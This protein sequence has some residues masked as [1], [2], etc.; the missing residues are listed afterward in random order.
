MMVV[1]FRAIVICS[2][3]LMLGILPARAQ[4]TAP[5]RVNRVLMDRYGKSGYRFFVEG[6]Y[7]AVQLKQKLFGAALPEMGIGELRWGFGTVEP[8]K[9]DF[10]H[11]DER[12][13]FG[14]YMR[15]DW[16]P[17]GT[18]G[19]AVQG[20]LW[21]VG[22]GARDGYGYWP[23]RLLITPTFLWGLEWSRW[24]EEPSQTLSAADSS[25]A[26]RYD[27]RICFGVTAEAGLKLQVGWNVS[28]VGGYEFGVVYPRV[29]FP[30]WV[31]GFGLVAT[32]EAVAGM[33]TSGLIRDAPGV[34]PV[35]HAVL[36]GAIAYGFYLAWRNDMN[37][38][39]PSE[40]PLTFEGFKAGISVKF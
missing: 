8:V 11:S 13:A 14:S 32:A 4:T 38:P 1:R 35:L 12:F 3:S 25:I 20:D 19:A 34:V 10:A 30:E 26:A 22:F 16:A 28:L 36:K 7:G 9:E 24:Q 37:W 23:G 31:A 33:I 15:P 5:P 18:S 40:T 39:F 17:S 21:R 2:A 27:H 6:E 29:V